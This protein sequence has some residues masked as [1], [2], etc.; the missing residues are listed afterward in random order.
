MA[1]DNGN[2]DLKQFAIEVYKAVGGRACPVYKNADDFGDGVPTNFIERALTYWV[3]EGVMQRMGL[4]TH[5]V[6]LTNE[7][8][9][10]IKSW[11]AG[12]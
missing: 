6:C 2:E 3:A 5:E 9:A 11:L 7:G 12:E 8:V 1:A 4:G 10:E